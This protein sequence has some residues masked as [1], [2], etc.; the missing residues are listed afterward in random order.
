MTAMADFTD[1]TPPD[2]NDAAAVERHKLNVL[3][4]FATLFSIVERGLAESVPKAKDL[5]ALFGGIPDRTVHSTNTRYLVKTFLQNSDVTVHE[6]GDSLQFDIER[7]ANCG[8]F[9]RPDSADIRILKAC[10]SGVPKPTSDARRAFYTSNQMSFVFAPDQMPPEPLALKLVLL[11]DV[12]ADLDYLGMWIA[13]P[14]DKNGDCFW[15]TKW[16]SGDAGILAASSGPSAPE[17]DLDEIVPKLPR[18]TRRAT[19]E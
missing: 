13:C 11:W 18:D 4:R 10:D 16:D 9:I 17:S 6:E 15:L 1:V 19:A 12:N 14:R 8:L 3:N 7:V 5:F 2:P